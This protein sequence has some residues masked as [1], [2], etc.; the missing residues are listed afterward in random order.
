MNSI[1]KLPRKD[2]LE[3][4]RV[5]SRAVATNSNHTKITEDVLWMQ[6]ITQCNIQLYSSPSFPEPKHPFLCVPSGQEMSIL[7]RPEMPPRG[8]DI[9]MPFL[10]FHLL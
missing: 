9:I 5:I 7:I 1:Y 3:A 2:K 10:G 4:Y 6:L 8:T